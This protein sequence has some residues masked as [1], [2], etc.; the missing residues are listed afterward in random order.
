MRTA[1]LFTVLS[2]ALLILALLGRAR[3]VPSMNLYFPIKDRVFG[4]Y[5]WQLFGA[6]ACAFFAFVYFAIGKWMPGSVKP[7]VGIVNFVLIAVAFLVWVLAG[8]LLKSSGRVDN[9]LIVTL[10]GAMLS[11]FL[12]AVFVALVAGWASICLLRA[13]V[14]C[15]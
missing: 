13:R 5:Y 7:F 10:L 1:K 15:R 2:T 6:V 12:G 9:W 4:P 14:F 3:L 11:F 8:F